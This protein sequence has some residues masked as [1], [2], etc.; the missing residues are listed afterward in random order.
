VLGKQAAQDAPSPV[1]TEYLESSAQKVAMRALEVVKPMEFEFTPKVLANFSPGLEL[2]T[3][4]GGQ[5]M[6]NY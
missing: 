6:K 2:A 4:V 5:V 3:T 1:G